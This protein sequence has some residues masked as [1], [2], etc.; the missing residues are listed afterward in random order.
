MKIMNKLIVSKEFIENFSIDKVKDYEGCPDAL[1]MLTIRYGKTIDHLAKRKPDFI[2]IV[3]EDNKPDW[4]LNF[5]LN[6]IKEEF[7]ISFYEP[8]LKDCLSIAEGIKL[9]QTCQKAFQA[10]KKGKTITYLKHQLALENLIKQKESELAEPLSE[11]S[12][13]KI[14]YQI[15]ICQSILLLLND[16][17]RLLTRSLNSSL[18]KI[19]D[20]QAIVDLDNARNNMKLKTIAMKLIDYSE[21]FED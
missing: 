15:Y 17:D 19:A 20:A 7:K 6:L 11:E 3:I 8:Y 16:A 2:K 21:I 1:R 14:Y 5:L 18:Q 10:F 4:I 13:Y 12:N 9:V